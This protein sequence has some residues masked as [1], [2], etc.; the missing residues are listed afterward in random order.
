MTQET[1]ERP[2]PT[3][4][5]NLFN[6]RISLQK[7]RIQAGNRVAAVERGAD[8]L[9]DDVTVAYQRIHASAQE[10]ESIIDELAEAELAAFPVYDTW[11][12]HVKGI[13]PMLAVQLLALLHEPTP[14][15]GPSSWTKAAGMDPRP[16]PDGTNR[17]PR[18][19]AGEGT[20][21]YHPGLRKALYLIATS[22]VR[23]GGYYRTVYEQRKA[24]VL[25]QHT[26]DKDWPP[27]RIDAV[28]RWM[29]VRL[30][31]SH[32]WEEYSRALGQGQGRRAYVLDVLN[33]P[34]Y[35]PPP[36]WDG[37]TKM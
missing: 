14:E 17:M 5:K 33:H 32:L 6:T 35:I 11:L 22:F 1:V 16:R 29:T 15:R 34:H 18:P 26:G 30:F 2:E 4:L 21:T 8:D 23:G 13:G 7:F 12:K 37:K 24:R 10:W 19:R 25:A 28:A 9:E 3:K 27:H 31:L 36:Q 20:I